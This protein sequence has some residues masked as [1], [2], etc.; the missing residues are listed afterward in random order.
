MAAEPAGGLQQSYCTR[1]LP[2][3]LL[4]LLVVTIPFLLSAR[5]SSTREATERLHL[6]SHLYVQLFVLY[7]SSKTFFSI[8]SLSYPVSF[9]NLFLAP[10]NCCGGGLSPCRVSLQ[11]CLQSSVLLL[12]PLATASWTRC[13]SS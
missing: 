9:L 6:T 12:P 2:F 5:S 4:D 7:S 1:C 3:S 13:A 10:R 8:L 11:S